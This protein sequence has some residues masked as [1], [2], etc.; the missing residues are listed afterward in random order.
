MNKKRFILFLK[1]THYSNILEKKHILRKKTTSIIKEFD[2]VKYKNLIKNSKKL[3]LK[4]DIFNY[5][6]I[7]FNKDLLQILY[8]N[9]IKNISLKN[10]LALNFK[11]LKEYIHKYKKNGENFIEVGC[12]YGSNLVRFSKDKKISFKKFIGIDL[13]LT[14]LKIINKINSKIITVAG[15]FYKLQRLN[16]P[17]KQSLIISNCFMMYK[18]H[19][20]NSIKKFL[21]L[22]PEY[23]II[24]EP[25]YEF[26]LKKTFY[27]SLVRKYFKINDY[28][29]NIFKTLKKAERKKLIKIIKIKK[30]LFSHNPL[31]PLSLIVIKRFK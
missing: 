23:I 12:G 15:D 19:N 29:K 2:Q 21:L 30:N 22:Q 20:L 10:Y 9:K 13:S 1:N 4:K 18:S 5:D 24:L 26:N 11:I 25:I 28:S 14:G 8:K 7:F 31:L 16:F 3:K 27:H 6:K 17:I